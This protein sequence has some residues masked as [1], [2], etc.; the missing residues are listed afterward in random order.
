[1][2]RNFQN[3][4]TPARARVCAC[5]PRAAKCTDTPRAKVERFSRSPYYPRAFSPRAPRRLFVFRFSLSRPTALDTRGEKE[6]KI[7]CLDI[8]RLPGE[9]RSV[10]K[11]GELPARRKEEKRSRDIAANLADGN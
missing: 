7:V 2:F 11:G 3:D 9:I 6:V 4:E 5:V 10:K 8:P 1:M